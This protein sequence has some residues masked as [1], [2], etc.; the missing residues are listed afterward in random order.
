MD[1]AFAAGTDPGPPIGLQSEL[2]LAVFAQLKADDGATVLAPLDRVWGFGACVIPSPHTQPQEFLDDTAAA[3]LA[4]ADWRICV[5]A[6]MVEDS[7]IDEAATA[8]ARA[9]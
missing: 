9:T 5:L 2:G 8:N 1:N 7:T 4:R 3:L 6:G